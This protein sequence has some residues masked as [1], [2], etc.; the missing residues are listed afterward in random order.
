MDIHQLKTFVTVAAEGSITR[1][2]ECLCLSQPAV[3]AH[4]K[5]MEDLL[6]LTLFIRTPRGMQLTSDGQQL[7]RKAEQALAAHRA[8]LEEA[9]RLRGQISGRLRL[10]MGGDGC[11]DLLGE[12]LTRLAEQYPDVEV[13]L[14]HGHS[15]DIIEKIRAGELDAGFYNTESEPDGVFTAV[16]VARFGLYLAAPPG[17]VPAAEQTDWAALERLPWIVCPASGTC[18]GRAAEA[19]FEQHR[20]RPARI[21]SIDREQITRKLV[22]GGVGVGLLHAATAKPAAANGEVE[23]LAEIEKPVQVLF[24]YR[25][26]REQMPLLAQIAS[27]VRTLVAQ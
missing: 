27:L 26:D 14:T 7:Q 1:A 22:A 11:S 5:A 10:G 3:S 18:C 2:A 20:I 16:E 19:V 9:G 23:L 4:I 21:I 24:A 15:E 6:G 25:T 8:V 17:L 12:L 13:T